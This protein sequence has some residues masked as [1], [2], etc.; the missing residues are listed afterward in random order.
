MEGGVDLSFE[1]EAKKIDIQSA[2]L[3]DVE[4]R[5][6]EIDTEKASRIHNLQENYSAS[7]KDY[8]EE[9]DIDYLDIEKQQLQLRRQFLLDRMNGWKLKL[10]F[11]ILTTIISPVITAY[12]VSVLVG[13]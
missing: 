2:S 1:Y 13:N 8:I 5:L 12:L 9:L 10:L 3:A 7:V 4:K 6:L 11:V